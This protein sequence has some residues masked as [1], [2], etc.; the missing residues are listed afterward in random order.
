[1]GKLDTKERKALPKK[2]FGEPSRRGYPM[3]DKGHAKAAKARAS[4]MEHKGKLS[5][6]EEEKIDAKADRVLDRRRVKVMTPKNGR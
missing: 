3:E 2:D 1:M 5:K 6:S 4:E